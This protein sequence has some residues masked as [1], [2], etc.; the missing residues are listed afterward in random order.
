MV[1]AAPSESASAIVVVLAAVVVTAQVF[2]RFSPI[3]PWKVCRGCAGRGSGSGCYC[4]FWFVRDF[5]DFSNQGSFQCRR[6]LRGVDGD[7]AG[8]GDGDGG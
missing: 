1:A 2:K 3:S 7:G 5:S 8:D 6:N 4:R